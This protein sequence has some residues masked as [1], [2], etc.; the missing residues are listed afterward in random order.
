MKKT[1]LMMLLLVSA[2]V[3]AQKDVTKFLGIPVDGYKSEMKRKLIDK[4]FTYNAQYDYL[5]GEFNGK[6]VNVFIATNNNKV[7][8]IMVSDANTCGEADIKI[9]F[10]N[11]C[12]QFARNKKYV[13]T[14][15]GEKDYTLSEDENISYE[16]LIHKKRYEASYYQL[17]DPEEISQNIEFKQTIKDALLREYTQAQLDNPTQKEAEDIERIQKKETEKYYF[18]LMEKKFV[19]FMISEHYGEYYISMFYDNEY[20]HSDGEDL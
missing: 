17:P 10:N 5:E 1:I 11:L 18:G 3:N 20:N 8:R 15:F 12:N 7:W 9:R 2:S 19:W 14:N 16:L 4:G 13:P 6:N